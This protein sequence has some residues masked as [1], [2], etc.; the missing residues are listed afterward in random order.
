MISADATEQIAE[1]S[2]RIAHE[3]QPD[4]IIRFGSYAYGQL[5]ADSDID[6]LVIMPFEGR[7]SAQAIRILNRLNMLAPID[8]LVR[9][10][11]EVEE[12][13]AMGDSFMR[14]LAIDEAALGPNH[15]NVARDLNNLGGVLESQGDLAQA[16]TLFEQ[17][18]RIVLEFLGIII[19]T[20]KLCKTIC[21]N[22]KRN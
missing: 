16:R 7:Q 11:E 10:P 17:S 15:P 5:S 12:R 18:L 6:L 13:L 2:E 9:R 8:L 21:G 14:A 4:K 3:F 22:L 19:H 1:L 20:L